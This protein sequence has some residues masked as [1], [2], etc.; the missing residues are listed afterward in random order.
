MT[1]RKNKYFSFLYHYASYTLANV[2][3]YTCLITRMNRTVI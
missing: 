2:M 1:F 3:M